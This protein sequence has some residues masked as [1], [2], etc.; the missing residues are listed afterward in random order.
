M[1]TEKI[2]WGIIGCGDVT[3]RKSGPAF[4]K[5]PDSQLVA[6]MRRNAAKAEDYARRH[7]VPRWY[8]R[9]EDLIHDPEVNAI[10]IATPPESHLAYT[11]LALEAGKPVYVEKPMTLNFTEAL[12]MQQLSE[13]HHDKI[14][15]AHYRRWWP[16]FVMVKKLLDEGEIGKPLRVH[17]VCS[18]KPLTPDEM[19]RP[20]VQWRI[21]PAVSGGGLFHDLAPHQID[22]LLYW[23]GAP[24]S[25][26]GFAFN[27]G[28]GYAADDT[29]VRSIRFA[30][31][32]NFF[33]IWHFSAPVDAQ[34]DYILIEGD[35]GTL[36]FS[37]FWNNRLILT[38]GG[39]IRE[40]AFDPPEHNQIYLI[41]QVVRFFRGEGPN[42][43]PVTE[44]LKGM[45]LME[46]RVV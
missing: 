13:Q 39:N 9:A 22:L 30:G 24:E 31:G 20:G 6:V 45:A 11:R 36:R 37:V 26:K 34:E 42:P 33:G 27:H 29:V 1:I 41:E 43:C 23:F 38:K 40:F 10:Y 18:R 25:C 15:V 44:G 17:L 28:G 35:A 7:G 16:P 19:Q 4:N 2:F 32:V 12:A 8:S 46:G 21:N 14:V 5:V 3:E